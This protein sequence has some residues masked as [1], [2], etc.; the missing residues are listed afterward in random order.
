[1]TIGPKM[2]F[3]LR[4]YHMTDAEN[5]EERERDDLMVAAGLMSARERDKRIYTRSVARAIR[6][7]D[8][9]GAWPRDVN[10]RPYRYRRLRDGK[11]GRWGEVIKGS[12][13]GDSFVR[14]GDEAIRHRGQT[15]H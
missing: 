2:A 15:K 9:A 13:D 3:I 6:R 5:E 4:V 11:V 8:N 14:V 1:M 12:R 10:T 7:R